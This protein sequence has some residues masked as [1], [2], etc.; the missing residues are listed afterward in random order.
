MTQLKGGVSSTVSEFIIVK[1]FQ[2]QY[3]IYV[4]P[5]EVF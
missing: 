5:R 4:L 1:W 2:G 3:R